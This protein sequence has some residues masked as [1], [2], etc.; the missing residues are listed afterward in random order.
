MKK[1]E[2]PAMT[3]LQISETQHEWRV[4][5]SLDGGYVGDGEVSGWFGD[6][7]GNNTNNNTNQPS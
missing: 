5:P 4:Q 2:T 7:D 1:W 3:E 6:D